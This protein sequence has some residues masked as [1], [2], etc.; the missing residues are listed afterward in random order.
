MNAS[1]MIVF[2]WAER[3]CAALSAE[4]TSPA[5]LSVET[6]NEL[7]DDWIQNAVL[8]IPSPEAMAL[9]CMLGVGYLNE[10]WILPNFESVFW[11]MGFEGVT[12]R[13]TLFKYL[14]SRYERYAADHP[15]A[16]T[17]VEETEPQYSDVDDSGYE[18]GDVDGSL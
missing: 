18:S 16:F 10:D 2:T 1:N 5:R 11:I 17:E 7:T 8:E 15:A 3:Y 6:L 13:L 14:L 9:T 12:G 4:F